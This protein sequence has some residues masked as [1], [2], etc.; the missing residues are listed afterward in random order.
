MPAICLIANP[1]SGGGKVVSLL[2]AV[3]VAPAA[4]S[5]CTHRVEMTRSLEHARELT[6]TALS[7]GE[8]P[9]SFSG[10][11]VAGAVTSAAAERPDSLVGVLPGGSGNDF[12]RH[13]GIPQDAVEACY[14]LATGTPAAIDLGEANGSALPRN[15][16]PRLRLA[17]PT[18][19][20]TARR[21]PSGAASTSTARSGPS[22]AGPRRTSRSR[23]TGR[24][25]R[26]EGWSVI[27]AN[28]SV[29]GGG[30]YV[31]PDARVDDGLLDVVMI[32][33]TEPRTVPR[34]ASPR[35]SRARTCART[36][37]RWCARARCG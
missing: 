16:E 1:T 6:R 2:P 7:D 4:S 28:T 19:S 11:G 30:M 33:K 26:F 32:R 9:V 21:A 12:C 5:A 22:R 15:R 14:V 23:S 10:D 34:L 20:R 18:R 8:L 29:Y 17:R 35:S 36:T 13:V 3:R 37:S 24:L 31:A 27:V 25:D